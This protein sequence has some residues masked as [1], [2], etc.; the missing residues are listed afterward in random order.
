MPARRLFA[1][2]AA[3]AAAACSPIQPIEQPVMT[4]A[5]IRADGSSAGNVRIFQQTTALLLRIDA[6]GLPPGQ[7]G[8]HVHTTGRCDAPGFESAGGHWNP[9][10]AQHGHQNPAGPHVGDLGNVGVGADGRL[11]AGL[12]VP[13]TNLHPGGTMHALH[14]GDGAALV[15]HATADDERTDP[16]GN[17]G[18]RIACAVLTPTG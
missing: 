10:S 2:S 4:A 5:L 1:I 9:T 8:V 16:S 17:S 13:S 15:I 7:H 11:L 3:A 18:A 14:D 6:T 12:L